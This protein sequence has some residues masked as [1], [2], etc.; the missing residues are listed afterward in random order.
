M[1]PD[2]SRQSGSEPRG[3]SREQ[4]TPQDIWER[5]GLPDAAPIGAKVAVD[6]TKTD[7]RRLKRE[8]AKLRD[9]ISERSE[10]AVYT[11]S[12]RLFFELG[13]PML[14]SKFNDKDKPPPVDYALL[15]KYASGDSTERERAEVRKNL[16][17][18]S[19]WKANLL[20][21]RFQ[22]YLGTEKTE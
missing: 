17:F 4:I 22:F 13:I 10:R 14:P 11:I 6:R 15:F 16:V 9:R 7:E 21:R 5:L 18:R 3:S 19:W 8:L 12:P 1:E 20:V 2:D